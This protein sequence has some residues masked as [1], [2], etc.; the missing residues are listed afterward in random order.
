MGKNYENLQIYFIP[1]NSVWLI[2][3]LSNFKE[4]EERL[5]FRANLG[6]KDKGIKIYKFLRKLLNAA[7]LF[8]LYTKFHRDWRMLNIWDSFGPKD[9]K[10]L[11]FTSSPHAVEFSMID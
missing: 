6:L 5:M 11:T 4:I 8:A 1:L 7:W 3:C 10:V 9:A 2:C